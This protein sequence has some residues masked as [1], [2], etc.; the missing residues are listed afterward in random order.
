MAVDPIRPNELSA[1]QDAAPARTER[2]ASQK[3]ADAPAAT[4]SKPAPAS[5]TEDLEDVKVQ[6]DND[7]GVVVQITDKKSGELVRQIPSEQV[8]NVA[9][10]IRELLQRQDGTAASNPGESMQR[11]KP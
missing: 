10:Y 6:W 1:V 4:A 7:N 8:L 9:R 5:A 11:E 2:G 3:H